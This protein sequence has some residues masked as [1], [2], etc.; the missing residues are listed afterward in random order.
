MKGSRATVARARQ[1]QVE[2]GIA[3]LQA[4]VLTTTEWF[5]NGVDIVQDG[6]RIS[7]HDIVGRRK[8][9]ATGQ[10]CTLDDVERIEETCCVVVSPTRTAEPRV[11]SSVEVRCTYAPYLDRQA[12][13]I[14]SWRKH[15]DMS[16]SGF[17]FASLKGLI[18]TEEL[19]KL[20]SIRPETI[21]SASKVSGVNAST[22]VMLVARQK[23]MLD[24]GGGGS[25]G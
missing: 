9:L 8:M 3:H 11:R 12:R 14:A 24:K 7:A 20:L 16:L 5:R 25:V 17:D 18:K 19:E 22:V 10:Q 6:K 4:M 15:S 13:E 1:E 2:R 23:K 21:Q